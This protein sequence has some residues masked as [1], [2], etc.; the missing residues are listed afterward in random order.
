MFACTS[1]I[2]NKLLNFVH[3]DDLIKA[4]NK[5]PMAEQMSQLESDYNDTDAGGAGPRRSNRKR[6]DF[7][8]KQ[9]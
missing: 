7:L 2:I 4:R 1:L 9:E 6:F 8:V 3:P 5:L